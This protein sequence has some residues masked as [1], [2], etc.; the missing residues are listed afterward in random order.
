MCRSTK[1]SSNSAD[2][3]AETADVCT[4]VLSL[5]FES[6]VTAKCKLKTAPSNKSDAV[7]LVVISRRTDHHKK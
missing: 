7:D 3:A 2:G 6:G 1:E 4:F 5:N